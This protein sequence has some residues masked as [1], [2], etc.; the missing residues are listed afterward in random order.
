MFY[1]LMD[2]LFYWSPS[3]SFCADTLLHRH[4]FLSFVFYFF[5][6]FISF[7]SLPTLEAHAMLFSVLPTRTRSAT[8]LL[9]TIFRV[10]GSLERHKTS[11]Y[12]NLE[13]YLI[14]EKDRWW[15]VYLY[16]PKDLK[17]FNFEETVWFRLLSGLI[18]LLGKAQ[19]N[20]G[21]SG[22]DEYS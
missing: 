22:L 20:L 5:N 17:C 12:T 8:R 15:L 21:F 1:Y 4:V 6:L 14:S 11:V 13:I 2:D 7:S 16:G 19:H 3:M 10:M 9:I 18:I